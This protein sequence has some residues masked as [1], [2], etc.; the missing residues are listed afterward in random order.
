MM[1]KELNTVKI[2]DFQ[3]SI[4]YFHFCRNQLRSRHSASDAIIHSQNN[5]IADAM[6]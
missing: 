5:I 1:E 6:P 4:L 3:C 2:P